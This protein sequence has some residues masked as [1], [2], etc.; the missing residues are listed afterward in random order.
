MYKTGQGLYTKETS[1]DWR[2]HL[3][4]GDLIKERVREKEGLESAS[5]SELTSSR[6][7]APVPNTGLPLRLSFPLFQFNFKTILKKIVGDSSKRLC[8][9]FCL[10][11][12]SFCRGEC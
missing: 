5:L 12:C 11:L 8:V 3:Q 10:S 7:N 1:K 9:S 2:E 6:K 4:A